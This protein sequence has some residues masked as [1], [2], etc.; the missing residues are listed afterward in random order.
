[1]NII[2]DMNSYRNITKVIKRIFAYSKRFLNELKKIKRS[3][4]RQIISIQIWCI[5]N[6]E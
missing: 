5:Q 1:M 6:N 3:M 2:I 4:P